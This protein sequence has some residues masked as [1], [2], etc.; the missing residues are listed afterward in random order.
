MRYMKYMPEG[1]DRDWRIQFYTARVDRARV[2][3]KCNKK[4]LKGDLLACLVA[5]GKWDRTTARHRNC[6]GET[7][8]R[9]PLGWTP[10]NGEQFTIDISRNSAA[11]FEYKFAILQTIDEEWASEEIAKIAMLD[12]TPDIEELR[13]MHG[14]PVEWCALECLRLR[15]E[16]TEPHAHLHK[17][18][19]ILFNLIQQIA[20]EASIPAVA[21]LAQ[22]ILDEK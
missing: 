7:I 2:C 20:S 6:V 13:L 3:P 8:W 4:I 1:V 19:L 5:E 11:Y 16:N 15:L 21:V 12:V 17:Y 9:N 18:H 14:M 22:Q 10:Y